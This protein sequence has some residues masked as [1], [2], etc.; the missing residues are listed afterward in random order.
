MIYKGTNF[1][2]MAFLLRADVGGRHVIHGKQ[3]STGH[4]T[5]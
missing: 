5:I 1:T 4:G 2:H 3:C